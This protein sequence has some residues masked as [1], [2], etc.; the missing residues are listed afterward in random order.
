MIVRNCVNTCMSLL[1]I[2]ASPFLA[3]FVIHH[4]QKFEPNYSR[5]AET[6]LKSTYIDDSMDSVLD[7]NEGLVCTNSYQN[8]GKRWECMHIN[9]YLILKQF[10]SNTC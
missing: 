8:Y 2:N 4:A 7:E 9:G 6:M 5:A 10:A 3:Q 1:V